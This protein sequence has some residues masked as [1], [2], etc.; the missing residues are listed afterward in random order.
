MTMFQTVARLYKMVGVQFA[1]FISFS[2]KSHESEIISI[3]IGYLEKTG[4]GGGGAG[5]VFERPP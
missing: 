3:F 5:R 1:D 2:L 4:G